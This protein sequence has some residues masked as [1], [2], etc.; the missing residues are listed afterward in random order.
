MD[1]KSLRAS[2]LK[3]K[4]LNQTMLNESIGDITTATTNK[5]PKRVSFH[6]SNFVKPFAVDQEK[7]TI[8]DNTYEEAANS[9]DSTKSNENT[10]TSSIH[11]S[12]SKTLQDVNV[13]TEIK[14][15]EKENYAPI[16]HMSSNTSKIDMDMSL[17]TRET[18]TIGLDVPETNNHDST[19]VDFT[20]RYENRPIQETNIPEMIE[21]IVHEEIRYN[22]SNIS[23]SIKAN[24]ETADME[25][26]NVLSPEILSS[27]GIIERNQ[28]LKASSQVN[29]K[30]N[31]FYPVVENIQTL[32]ITCA[33]S[34]NQNTTLAMDITCATNN[35]HN[36]MSAMDFTCA[37][38]IK[39]KTNL[40]TMDFTCAS[41]N[42]PNISLVVD[43]TC[44]SANKHDITSDMDFTCAPA[45][46]ENN[47]TSVMDLTCFT[48]EHMIIDKNKTKMGISKDSKLDIHVISTYEHQPN[49]KDVTEAASNLKND[50]L[51]DNKM[52]GCNDEFNLK[53]TN[54]QIKYSKIE[55]SSKSGNINQPFVES[56]NLGIS[57]DSKLDIDVIS[58]HPQEKQYS[59]RSKS[60]S[61]KITANTQTERKVTK[62]V[63]KDVE[64]PDFSKNEHIHEIEKKQ[65][66][67]RSKTKISETISVDSEGK[68]IKVTKLETSYDIS[69]LNADNKELTFAKTPNKLEQT[70][71]NKKGLN[72]TDNKENAS[73]LC[74]QSHTEE[75][76]TPKALNPLQME[77]TPGTSFAL[78]VN[79]I[80]PS[81]LETP[82]Y[83][84][85]AR[86]GRCPDLQKATEVC[87]TDNLHK[88]VTQTNLI[89]DHCTD[90]GIDDILK[91][92]VEC[93]LFDTTP[94]LDTSDPLEQLSEKD[95][96]KNNFG[97]LQDSVNKYEIKS[98]KDGTDQ[99][100]FDNS[101]LEYTTVPNST[102]L[103][104]DKIRE[105]VNG[106][107]TVFDSTQK[108][109][110][111]LNRP[112]KTYERA[113]HL[114]ENK[115]P[116]TVLIDLKELEKLEKEYGESSSRISD[117]LLCSSTV[118]SNAADYVDF[119]S[120]DERLQEQA[121]RSI[122]YWQ[123]VKCE[124]NNCYCFYTVYKAVPFKVNIDPNS[125]TVHEIETF[126]NLIDNA[127]PLYFYKARFMQEKL[128][129]VNLFLSLGNKFDIFS[130]LDYVIMCMEEIE[131]FDKEYDELENDFGQEHKLTMNP[132]FSITIE[133]LSEEF[134]LWWVIT[135]DLSVIHLGS[136]TSAKAHHN[137]S[138][139]EPVN[140]EDIRK[141]AQEN[142]GPLFIRNF[143]NAINHYV[144]RVGRKRLAE[145]KDHLR[146]KYN[147][148]P[149]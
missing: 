17:C 56:T 129:K 81:Q 29:N 22:S 6:S 47:L 8:W 53:L 79:N 64:V 2:I 36:D 80:R 34:K 73:N 139:E 87:F 146:K 109:G 48:S 71:M 107:Q 144:K 23:T 52:I 63:K 91:S 116:E 11:I 70:Y 4:S 1:R 72:L 106:P 141:I 50:S 35:K 100:S 108:S 60:K 42:Q 101:K 46:I 121:K 122:K 32:D 76:F 10:G 20:C 65:Y 82:I 18:T 131:A 59:T 9:I 147:F 118:D 24:L 75:M 61:Q 92:N 138:T 134:I 3:R 33:P 41:V 30:E 102:D 88:E 38:S 112:E 77:N 84:T 137:E 119:Q 99:K 132:D 93:T 125:G 51:E 113:L 74:L 145:R 44:A 40:T 98:E 128:K 37:Q 143:I 136:I 115:M 58:E 68:S 110:D 117:G 13:I 16:V 120:L 96:M 25:L 111:V 49:K 86:K 7:C 39:Q 45:N 19:I 104:L 126:I 130:L 148:L 140:E 133:I 43:S 5:D 31:E 14:E 97:L 124:D 78:I 114:K 103:V 149:F 27:H 94:L 62:N 57:K 85:N 54:E 83:T 55:A 26:T 69:K 15:N 142:A 95:A 66:T 67:T 28:V 135:V 127:L 89:Y 105:I 12:Q 123:F 21:N 90:N